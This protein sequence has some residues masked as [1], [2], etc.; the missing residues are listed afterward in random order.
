MLS[1]LLCLLQFFLVISRL[2]MKLAVCFVTDTLLLRS[3]PTIPFA[4]DHA[5]SG[6]KSRLDRLRHVN[7]TQCFDKP[8]LRHSQT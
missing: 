7:G 3:N 2:S 1:L 6:G 8:L 5:F 4:T